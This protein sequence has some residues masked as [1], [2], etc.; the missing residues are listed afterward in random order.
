MFTTSRTE[1]S[2]ITRWQRRAARLVD[3][4]GK[5]VGTVG[6]P[7]GYMTVRLSPDGRTALFARTRP[8]IGTWDLYTTDLARNVERRLTSDPGSEAY[9]VWMPDGLA[10]LFA[11]G[12]H[13][14]IS[15]WRESTSTLVSKINCSHAKPCS[16]G[17]SMFAGRADAPLHRAFTVGTLD[18]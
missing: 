11:D 6:A 9:P 18:V 7:A 13:G 16:G 3:R 12:R 17:R 2:P 1:Q 14:G 8:G 10:I 15:I 4:T 5:E